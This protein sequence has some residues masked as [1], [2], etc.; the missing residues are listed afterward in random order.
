MGGPVPY[1]VALGFLITPLQGCQNPGPVCPA[2][3][4]RAP[5]EVR[6]HAPNIGI[7]SHFEKLGSVSTGETVAPYSVLRGSSFPFV[8]IFEEMVNF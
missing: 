7:S 2:Q 1:G 6:G 5:H 4:R 8:F 3:N